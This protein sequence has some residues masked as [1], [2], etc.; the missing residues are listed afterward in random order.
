MN[1]IIA[2]IIIIIVVLGSYY[3]MKQSISAPEEGMP[4][5]GEQDITEECT[6][7]DSCVVFGETGDCNCGC[8]S[9]DNL[10]TETGGECFCAAPDSCKCIDNKCEGIFEDNQEDINSFKEC[11]EAG[12]P[13]L[14]TYPLQCKT[15]DDQAFTEEHCVDKD[16]Q[17]ILSLADAKQIAIESECGNRLKDTYVCNENTGTY[18]IDLN[19]EKQ[20]CN[21][22]CVIDITNREGVINWRCTGLI[23]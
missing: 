1:K 20:G 18:W 4:L 19:I 8:Y 2:T 10:P 7:D 11:T 3:L 6:D 9:K 15:D 21:P 23:Q 17:N 16:T 12:Y 13:I 22:A 14:E 5:E